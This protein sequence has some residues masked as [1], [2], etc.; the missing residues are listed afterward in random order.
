MRTNNHLI[1]ELAQKQFKYSKLFE[2]QAAILRK[3]PIV[4][5]TAYDNVLKYEGIA[6]EGQQ[7]MPKADDKD[8]YMKHLED[9]CAIDPK[10]PDESVSLKVL[11][12]FYTHGMNSHSRMK[13]CFAAH[14]FTACL[15]LLDI[16]QL[17]TKDRHGVIKRYTELQCVQK[18]VSPRG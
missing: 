13:I 3:N 9:I 8:A 6:K 14:A 7:W 12:V 5:Q 17:S 15:I 1:E 11:Y 4:Y 18:I 10:T 16:G 2:D